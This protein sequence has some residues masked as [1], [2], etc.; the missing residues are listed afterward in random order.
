M[1]LKKEFKERLIEKGII[2]TTIGIIMCIVGTALAI[3]S[4]PVMA[5]S[6]LLIFGGLFLGL[7]DGELKGLIK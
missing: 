1:D 7:K 6:T 2:N 5:W 3:G 4:Y